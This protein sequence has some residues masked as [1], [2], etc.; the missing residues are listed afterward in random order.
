MNELP[1]NR[2]IF[3]DGIDLLKY[4]QSRKITLTVP[5]PSVNVEKIAKDVAKTFV[6]ATDSLIEYLYSVV[7]VG[8]RN[9][10]RRFRK[11][12]GGDVQVRPLNKFSE[13][14][15]KRLNP[16]VLKISKILLLIGVTIVVVVGLGRLVRGMISTSSSGKAS[17]AGAKAVQDLN[18]E[19]SF[20]LRNGNN[21]EVSQI[22]YLIEKA[23]L[24]DEIIVQGQR[25]TAVKGRVFLILTLK[26]TNDY[27]QAIRLNPQIADLYL[28]RGNA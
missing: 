21:E 12:S 18:R 15:R 5:A 25:A 3:N 9:I 4:M 11:R 8:L 26:I 28:N 14:R 19:F 23:E 17:V 24:R 20:P 6:D 2:G 7:S 16:Q 1:L 13:T 22:K 27:D 10:S